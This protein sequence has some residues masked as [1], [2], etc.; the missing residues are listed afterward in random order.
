MA[1][2]TERRS[3]LS[4]VATPL[5]MLASYLLPL[6]SCVVGAPGSAP[7]RLMRT[8][9]LGIDRGLD[10]KVCDRPRICIE[11]RILADRSLQRR[12]RFSAP[13]ATIIRSIPLGFS[14]PECL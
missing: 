3:L 11:P 6:A 14:P 2:E 4:E 1:A 13:V 12:W 8:A 5:L 7:R 10:F 9:L